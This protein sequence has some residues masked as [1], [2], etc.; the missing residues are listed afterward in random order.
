MSDRLRAIVDGLAIGPGDRVLEIGCGHG[1]TASYVCERL[2]DAG[3]LVAIDR[4]PKMIAAAAGRNA[5]H[6]ASG[7]A[8][9]LVSELETL[10]LGDQ[11]FDLVFAIRVGLFH[12]EPRHARELAERWLAPGGRVEAFFDPPR[13][14]PVLG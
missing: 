7:R 6:V 14:R 3:R 2:G 10:D 12:R 5:A 1:V 11:R 13:R 9:F 8:E 4:S